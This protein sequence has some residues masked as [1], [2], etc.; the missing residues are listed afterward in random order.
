MFLAFLDSQEDQLVELALQAI[1]KLDRKYR[2]QL[3][4]FG[5]IDKIIKTL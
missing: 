5:A 2:T 3:L 4:D 1:Y